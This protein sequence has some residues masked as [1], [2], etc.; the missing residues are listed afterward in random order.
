MADEWRV[1]ASLPKRSRAEEDSP[2]AT[3]MR[4][5]PSRISGDIKVSQNGTSVFLYA[6]SAPAAGQAEQVVRDVL[7]EHDVTADVR[8]DRWNPTSRSWTSH[9]ALMEAERRKSAATGRAAWQV[10]VGPSFPHELKAL[11]QRLEV[12]RSAVARR[13]M[14][15]IIGASCEDDA[16]ALADQIQGYISADTRIRVQPGVYDLPPVQAWVPGAGDIWV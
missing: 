12:H 5:L 14:Y 8:R 6:A 2:W 4:T 16:H 7:A 10:R 11:T 1:S 3:A 13:W 9:E 15:L